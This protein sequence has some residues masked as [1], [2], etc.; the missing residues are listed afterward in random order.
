MRKVI[1]VALILINLFTFL[2]QKSEYFYFIKC[3]LGIR[4]LFYY[5]RTFNSAP[6]FYETALLSIV[7]QS[8]LVGCKAVTFEELDT[9]IN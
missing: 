5:W 8:V 7:W 6:L 9:E 2:L 4:K 1:S 3:Q